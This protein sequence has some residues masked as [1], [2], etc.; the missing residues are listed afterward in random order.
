[1]SSNLFDTWF[2]LTWSDQLNL[3][4]QFIQL[5]LSKSKVENQGYNTNVVVKLSWVCKNSCY[6]SFQKYA[7]NFL[8]YV[9][10]SDRKYSQWINTTP[11]HRNH[12][13]S[14]GADT[15]SGLTIEFETDYI[16]PIISWKKSALNWDSF[17]SSL[18]Q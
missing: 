12:R 9:I 6:T 2:G 10:Y 14:P 7:D 8:F 1:M 11:S 17:E 18:E 3:N 4:L 13:I 15:E 5:T 16:N